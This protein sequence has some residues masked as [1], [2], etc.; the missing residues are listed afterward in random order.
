[1][2]WA[3]LLATFLVALWCTEAQE[4]GHEFL[5]DYGAI[6]ED[7]MALFD[8]MDVEDYL[9]DAAMHSF[10]DGRDM[11]PQSYDYYS[12]GYHPSHHPSSRYHTRYFGPQFGRLKTR[13]AYG[14]YGA[15]PG[16]LYRYGA[17]P[18]SGSGYSR[19]NIKKDEVLRPRLGGGVGIKIPGIGQLGAGLPFGQGGVFGNSFE[20]WLRKVPKH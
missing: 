7:E 3:L 19:F 16:N 2:Y 11:I 10:D 4:L 1:M 18:R 14:G 8:N 6:D 20:R 5:D 9:D 17:Y 13:Y 15:Y 12:G